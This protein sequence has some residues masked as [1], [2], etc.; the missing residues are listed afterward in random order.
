MTWTAVDQ[1]RDEIQC[2]KS[3][4]ERAELRAEQAGF[5]DTAK[6]LY[7]ARLRMSEAERELP[8]SRKDGEP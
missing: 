6:L 5:R 4:V 8:S 3:A 2:L 1:M 7:D